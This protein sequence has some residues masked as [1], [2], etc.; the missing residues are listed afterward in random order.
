[1]LS[2]KQYRATAEQLTALVNLA[3]QEAGPIHGLARSLSILPGCDDVTYYKP[4][5]FKLADFV[6]PARIAALG[7]LAWGLVDV[8]MVWTADAV[9]AYFGKPAFINRLPALDERG[10]REPVPGKASQHFF[11]RAFDMD[12]PGLSAEEIRGEIIA[13]QDIPA[14]R[15]ITR[16]ERGVNWLHADCAA[17]SQRIV[18]FNP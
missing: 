17:V 18:L 7:A 14:F 6:P 9:R 3:V 10:F 16:M 12:I 11:G 13:R 8:R 4:E 15:F 1:M 2:P 5:Y